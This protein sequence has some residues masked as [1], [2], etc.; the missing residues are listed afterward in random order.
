MDRNSIQQKGDFVKGIILS[1]GRGSRLHPLTLAV[2]KQLLPVYD[3]PMIYY[4]LSTLML[5]GIREI[6]VISTPLDLTLYKRVLGSGAQWGL[7]FEFLD[8]TEPNGIAQALLIGAE[9]IGNDTVALILGDN[10]FYGATLPER[11]RRAAALQRGAIVFAYQ[12]ADPSHYAVITF[13]PDSTDHG[14]ALTLSEKPKNPRSQFAVPGLYFYDNQVVSIAKKMKPSGRGELE[15]TDINKVYLKKRELGVEVL[16]RGVAW[17][18]AGR[19]ETLLQAS[20]FIQTIQERQGLMISCPEEIA[21]RSGYISEK[22]LK[23][24]INAMGKNAYRSYLQTIIK[25]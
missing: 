23:Q 5:A 24:L 16:G 12:V 19:S 17:L 13:K 9:F 4:P 7:R 20:T 11:L 8:Q 15:I 18:D 25:A 3:K 2:S 1:G 14:Q 10:I 22:K 21:Y 6:L